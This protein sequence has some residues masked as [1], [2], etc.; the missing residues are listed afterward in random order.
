MAHFIGTAG[1][2]QKQRSLDR[3]L[4]ALLALVMVFAAFTFLLGFV[5]GYGLGH[6][7]LLSVT[8][9][10]ILAAITYPTFKY[11]EKRFD[12]QIHDAIFDR[13]GWDGE[14]EFML[15]LKDLPDTYTVISDLDFADSYGNIDYLIIGPTGLFSIDVKNWRGIVSSNGNGE[16]L[17]NG[18][19]TDKPQIRYF[20][21]RTMELKDRIKALTTLDPYVQCVFAFLRTRVEANWGTTGHVHCIRAEQIADYVTKSRGGKPISPV[22]IPRLVKAAEALRNL[23][24]SQV[25]HSSPNRVDQG[26]RPTNAQSPASGSDEGARP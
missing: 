8:P 7:G 25:K 16:L 14:R 5:G 17:L 15:H 11:L 10:L 26:K 1:E 22:D 2:F 6:S 20:T 3:R 24:P 9:I 19:P 4:N 21:R 13:Q 18:K 12:K 23:A